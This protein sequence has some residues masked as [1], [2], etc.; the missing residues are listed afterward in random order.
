[1]DRTSLKYIL[2]GSKV[3]S[4]RIQGDFLH[5]QRDLKRN[6][7]IQNGGKPLYTCSR[8]GGIFL[9]SPC[10]QAGNTGLFTSFD[11][12]SPRSLPGREGCWVVT[13]AC[14]GRLHILVC[15][16]LTMFI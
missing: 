15:L 10:R 4:S 11:P 9:T 2:G 14:R 12:S 7:L 5:L 16:T 3:T 13:W 1:M 8:G 6:G